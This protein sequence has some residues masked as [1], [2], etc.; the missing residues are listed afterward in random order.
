V[1][2]VAQKYRLPTSVI[3]KKSKANSCPRGKY[4]PKSG[5]DVMITIFYDFHQF[6]TKK[7]A[8]FLKTNV[9]DSLFAEFRSVLKSKRTILSPIF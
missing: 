1:K 4:S 3:L 6:S 9:V 5:V 2:K 7:M 8:F